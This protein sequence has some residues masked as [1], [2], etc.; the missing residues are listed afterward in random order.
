M[1]GGCRRCRRITMSFS[2]RIFL[3]PAPS[4]PYPRRAHGYL[5]SQA[6]RR[7]QRCAPAALQE[8]G[9]ENRPHEAHAYALHPQA[10]GEQAPRALTRPQARGIPH[11]EQEEAVLLE[12]VK[13]SFLGCSLLAF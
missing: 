5:R 11:G 2:S 13:V 3:A 6:R 4:L 1:G 8:A 7:I 9:A 10:Q 12:Y